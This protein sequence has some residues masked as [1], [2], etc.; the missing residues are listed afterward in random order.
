MQIILFSHDAKKVSGV[1][2]FERNFIKAFHGSHSITYVYNK[3]EK[4]FLDSISAFVNIIENTGQKFLC[5]V[6]I[7]SSLKHGIVEPNIKASKYVQICHAN[8]KELGIEYKPKK[9]D[10]HVSVGHSVQKVLREHYDIDSTV[11]PNILNFDTPNRVLRLITASRITRPKGFERIVEFAKF[12]KKNN[13]EFIWEIYGEGSP[14]YVDKIKQD[15]KDIPEVIF[16]GTRQDMRGYIKNCDYLV[17]FS[18]N[19]GFCYAVYEALQMGVPCIV[20][21]YDGVEQVINDE[22]NGF[23]LPMDLNLN[24]KFVDKLYDKKLRNIVPPTS[25][26]VLYW[27][28]L[29]KQLTQ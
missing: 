20:T 5:D 3:A 17:Q 15:L 24:R 10:V 28:T 23:I 29:L 1:Q 21:N 22:V 7:Y 12:L 2:T 27:D 16:M 4:E 14:Q 8:I 25:Y 13:Y 9:I 6:C 26:A 11:I 18:D 19:E